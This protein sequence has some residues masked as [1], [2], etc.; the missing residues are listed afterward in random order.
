[1]G[2][3][4]EMKGF[5]GNA[6]IRET[7]EPEL[8]RKINS[9]K[10]RLRRRRLFVLIA[11]LSCAAVFLFFNESKSSK[12]RPEVQEVGSIPVISD[13]IPATTLGRPGLERKIKYIVIHETGNEGKN[14][15]AASHNEYLH[16]EADNQLTSWHY[17]VDD[18]EIYYHIPDNELAFHAGDGQNKNGGNLCGIGI[19]MCINPENDYEK[20]LENTAKLTAYLLKAYHLKIDSV[21][22]HQDFS[23]K[24]CPERL[25]DSGGWQ[26][27]LQSVEQEL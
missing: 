1:M 22:K 2:E 3:G 11:I 21:H 7:S 20:T 25:I 23:G 8:N 12:L 24:V 26:E 5:D 14:A 10:R 18:H 17:T 13:F 27:F 9:R 16:R 19:E 6:G 4:E 15:D